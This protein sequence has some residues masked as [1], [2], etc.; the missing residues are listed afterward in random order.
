MTAVDATDQTAVFERAA[1]SIDGC[2]IV[3]DGVE[4]IGRNSAST[5]STVMGHTHVKSGLFHDPLPT[6]A[7]SKSCVKRTNKRHAGISCP[8]HGVDIGA[9]VEIAS[10]MSLG[11]ADKLI[12]A[13]RCVDVG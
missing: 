12:C 3:E 8:C 11:N 2:K 10:E 9:L 6:S 5:T 7:S 13:E 1:A 4:V